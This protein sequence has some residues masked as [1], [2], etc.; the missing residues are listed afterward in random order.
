MEAPSLEGLPDSGC[1]SSHEGV[2]VLGWLLPLNEG[3]VDAAAAAC[4]APEHVQ[5]ETVGHDEAVRVD[6]VDQSAEHGVPDSDPLVCAGR[7]FAE[8][9]L[10][11]EIGGVEVVRAVAV[12]L[13]LHAVFGGVIAHAE[14]GAVTREERGQLGSQ[15]ASNQHVGSDDGVAVAPLETEVA[16]LRDVDERHVPLL[17]GYDTDLPFQTHPTV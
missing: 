3:A 14:R 15:G 17:S 8:L 11:P 4:W 12:E 1:N 6:H 5:N 7:L 13:H 9:D 16:A 2:S 10:D